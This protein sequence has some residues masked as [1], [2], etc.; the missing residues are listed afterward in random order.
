MSVPALAEISLEID[1]SPLAVYDLVADIT[2]V[3]E[4]SSEC[5]GCERLTTERG[6]GARFN[7]KRPN[8]SPR[9][10]RC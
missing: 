6:E 7:D 8:S 2:R 10:H 9:D 4:W 3:G 1:A 5:T